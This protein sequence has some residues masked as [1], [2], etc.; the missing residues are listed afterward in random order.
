M[1]INRSDY[2]SNCCLNAVLRKSIY[3]FQEIPREDII[4]DP[5]FGFKIRYSEKVKAM[6]EFECNYYLGKITK[7]ATGHVWIMRK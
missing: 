3:I 6:D 2:Q 4:F 7:S 1:M 5:M